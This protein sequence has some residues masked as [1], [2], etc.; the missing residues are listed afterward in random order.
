[1]PRGVMGTKIWGKRWEAGL[2]E[3]KIWDTPHKASDPKRKS[4]RHKTLTH[5]IPL[6]PPPGTSCC[7]TTA[8]VSWET[9][10]SSKP[11]W[12]HAGLCRLAA[13]ACWTQDRHGAFLVL[14]MDR[15]A[16]QLLEGSGEGPLT[17]RT[18]STRQPTLE[19]LCYI[20]TLDPN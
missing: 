11:C 7:I 16:W 15:W 20:A 18:Q 6:L 4:R 5:M 8:W 14:N 10:H 3:K 17:P 1:M 19:M 2:G 12:P 9:Q 13:P